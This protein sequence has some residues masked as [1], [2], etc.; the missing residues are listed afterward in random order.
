MTN[1]SEE[2]IKRPK[3]LIILGAGASFGCTK[4]K[5]PPLTKDIARDLRKLS[6]SSKCIT[7]IEQLEK[8]S[9]ENPRF[10]FEATLRSIFDKFKNDPVTRGQFIALRHSLR[11]LFF[12]SGAGT[13]D[14]CYSALYGTLLGAEERIRTQRGF[15]VVNLNYDL[16]AQ[17]GFN[18]RIPLNN[19]Q[20][21]FGYDSRPFSMFHPHGC[22]T[23]FELE[24]S[25]IADERFNSAHTRQNGEYHLYFSSKGHT[26]HAGAAFP[27]NNPPATNHVVPS[28]AL[29][30]YGDNRSKTV[31]PDTHKKRCARELGSVDRIIVIGWR[32]AD[33][34][35]M[36][37]IEENIDRQKLE[38]IHLVDSGK[39]IDIKSNLPKPW[40]AF[41][42]TLEC[43]SG[44][45]GYVKGTNPL[46][47]DII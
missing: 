31:W 5:R 23:W 29:P 41:T 17:R 26:R 32:G 33:T 38:K 21:Y 11:S 37:F 10:D 30:M 18:Q 44:F 25:N 3:T 36:N 8:A 22:V 43:S 34:H 46:I 42:P 9:R 6:E 24:K 2:Y 27:F 14:T 40:T 15:T 20:N 19:F 16:L 7:I 1:L 35:I 47:N 28:L 4:A 45:E 39:P 13:Q 12:H